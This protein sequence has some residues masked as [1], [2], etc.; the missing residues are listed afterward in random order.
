MSC[1]AA[2]RS[3][4]QSAEAARESLRCTHEQSGRGVRGD[5]GRLQQS[6]PETETHVVIKDVDWIIA[7]GDDANRPEFRE[8][9]RLTSRNGRFHAPDREMVRALNVR[10]H[11]VDHGLES[12]QLIERKRWYA[13]PARP[14]PSVNP[15]I[16][17]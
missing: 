14:N 1:P 4:N 13:Y 7:E 6:Q 2:K 8:D 11:D 9:E 5:R 10:L 3:K 15:V 16:S 17:A 12:E